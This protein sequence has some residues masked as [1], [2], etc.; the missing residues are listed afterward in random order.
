MDIVGGI[1]IRLKAKKEDKMKGK[2]VMY[3][4][5][6]IGELM[7]GI[8]VFRVGVD[9]KKKDVRLLSADLYSSKEEP[10]ETVVEIPDYIG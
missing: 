1:L 6:K 2:D 4:M 3:K 10:K 9:S 5:K 7:G 8:T